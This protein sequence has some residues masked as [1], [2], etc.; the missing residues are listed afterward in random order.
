MALLG[1]GRSRPLHM[2]REHVF[3]ASV[4]LSAFLLF[5]L[6]PMLARMLLPVFG[7]SPAV[8]N[9]C[10]VF[11]QVLLLAGY[12]YAHGSLRHMGVRRQ[13]WLHGIV[14]AISLLFLPRMLHMTLAA[15]ASPV[16]LILSA[17]T[18]IAGVPFFV[19]S[20]NSS[21]TQRWFSLA[22]LKGS[23][24]PFWL[25]AASNAGSLIALLAYPFIFEP[26]FGVR[27]QIRIWSIGYAAFV[28]LSFVA[29][30]FASG[31]ALPA[32]EEAPADP[33]SWKRRMRW[34]VLA[35]V[36]SSLLLSVTMQITTEIVSAPLFWVLPLALYLL[37][38]I[39]AFS[40]GRRPQRRL[41]VLLTTIGIAL[42]FT[43]VLVP[44]VLPLWASLVVLLGTLFT[45]A[46]ICHG[47][48][49]DDRP[50]AS[51]LTD[52][53]L[54]LAVGGMVGGV[55]NSIVAP[56]LFDSVAEY[57]ITLACLA[58]VVR[59]VP[60]WRIG[61]AT[62]VAAAVAA[63]AMVVAAAMVV[64]HR[65]AGAAAD[66]SLFHWQFMPLAVLAF[67]LMFAPRGPLFPIATLLVA[68]FMIGGLH[69]V[70]PIVDQGRSFFGVSRV[71]ETEISRVMVH[72][73]TVHGAQFK[74]ARRHDIPVSYYYPRGPL[75]SAVALSPD[76]ADIGVVG[77]GA[78]SLAVLTRPGQ[79]LT[80]FEID[81]LVERMAR[82]NFTFLGDAGARPRVKI[83]DGRQLLER[84]ADEAFD[85]LVIDAFSSD[86]IPMHLIT[87][88]AIG[89]YLRKLKPTGLL[90]FHISNRYADL[91]RVFRGWKSEASGR[92]VAISQFVPSAEEQAGGVLPTV[93]I[94][95]GRSSAALAPLAATRQWYW[96]DD[97]GPAV[98]WTDDHADL[99]SVLNE[100]FLKP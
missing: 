20:T 25:Y 8:W 76:S 98:H 67:G 5:L 46:L 55:A 85:L 28:A 27:T 23:G 78:G 39:I 54:W 2:K 79:Q 96:L 90:V 30:R 48:L 1:V 92:R 35:A 60:H 82:T 91:S 65:A 38:F 68:P 34:V 57:P 81:P 42:C 87:E 64:T 62:A 49:A 29:M 59:P 80:Y 37:T 22:A 84:E 6:Q 66:E 99:L 100:N 12:A 50:S 11:F 9:T 53:Y 75:G 77:L 74:D 33:V 24:D 89:V 47:D 94:A 95:I 31:E 71:I 69:F 58:F 86:A 97:T 14:L 40:Q 13:R 61:R 7:G 93:A 18:L 88:E 45:G 17:L 43:I 15:T 44:T 51:D 19:L 16:L 56:L 21:L 72:G 41:L 83:G 52:F 3:V 63:S 10:M 36:A 4:F 26:A 32:A 70:E 73:V